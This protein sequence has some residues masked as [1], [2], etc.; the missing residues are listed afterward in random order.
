MR[1]RELGAQ[2]WDALGGDLP[3]PVM[4]LSGPAL[5]ANVDA[6]GGLLPRARRAARAARQDHDGAAGVRPPDRRQAPGR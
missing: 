6:D 2:G 3:L 4:L 5:Q 1:M